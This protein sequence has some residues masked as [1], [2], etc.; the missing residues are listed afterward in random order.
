MAPPA[1]SGARDIPDMNK[2]R[3]KAVREDL[4]RRYDHAVPEEDIDR[5]FDDLV[6]HH[7]ETAKV[8]TFLPI[9]VEREATAAI[10]KA[11]WADGTHT[12]RQEILFVCPHNT[13]RSQI[14]SVVAR[15]YAG[16][17]ALIRSVGP[18]PK[19]IENPEIVRE[20]EARG[21]DTSLVYPKELTSRTIHDSDVVI[22]LGRAG[23]E[24]FEGIATEIWEV[25]DPDNADSDGVKAA[26]D[27]IAERVFELL[28]KR[29]VS[30]TR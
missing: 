16:E 25:P 1:S 4:H 19:P 18:D 27:Q 11:A 13:G 10:E 24:D 23:L 6:A 2:L 5:Y 9:I 14:A 20:L 3:F 22:L 28:E 29:E 26:V 8:R 12:R 17:Q 30:F 21:F 15:H 7:E